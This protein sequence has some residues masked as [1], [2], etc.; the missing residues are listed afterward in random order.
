MTFDVTGLL[1]FLLAVIPG[2]LAEQTRHSIVP[3]SL[4]KKSA[5]EET[6]QYVIDSLLIH[7]L[8]LMVFRLLLSWIDPSALE[9]LGQAITE[10]K[11]IGW[12]WEH[13]YLVLTYFVLS[14]I[15]GFFFGL[16]RGVL[17]LNQPFR[18]KLGSFLLISRLLEGIGLYSFLQT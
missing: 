12:G 5:I 4:Q 7:F 18:R 14:L 15:G 9:A 13:H 10:K 11:L 17:S 1:I 16:L 8:L 3:R 6:G 2:F